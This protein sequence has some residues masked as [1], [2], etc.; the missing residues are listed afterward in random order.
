MESKYREKPCVDKGIG[1]ER[2]TAQ[3]G[4][5]MAP[6]E[7]IKLLYQK[8]LNEYWYILRD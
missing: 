3:H 5:T 4:P 6:T 7:S 1:I 8:G 2:Q